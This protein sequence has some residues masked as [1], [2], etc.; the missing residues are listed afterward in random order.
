MPLKSPLPP[1]EASPFATHWRWLLLLI[2]F[3]LVIFVYFYP[4]THGIEDEA[5]YINQAFLWQHGSITA[6]GAGYGQLADFYTINGRSVSF[7]NP[8]RAL[9]LLPFMI[10]FGERSVFFTGAIIHVLTV[11]AAALLLVRLGKSPLWALLILLH[12]TMTLYSR[13]VMSDELSGL[14]LLLAVLAV[15]CKSKRGLLA[16]IALGAAVLTRYHTAV[17][18]PF[19]IVALFF[20]KGRREAFICLLTT[21]AFAVLIVAYNY[22]TFRNLVGGYS[23]MVSF[24][25]QY[26]A[27]SLKYYVPAL[28]LL[29]PLQLFAPF[30]DRSP[31]RGYVWACCFPVFGLLT[32]YFFHETGESLVQTL[33]LGQR[34]M[35]TILPIWI[36]SYI[37]TVDSWTGTAIH[38]Y[39]PHAI[40]V[41]AVTACCVILLGGTFFLFRE[42]QRHLVNLRDTAAEIE[43]VAPA[44][45]VLVANRN[46]TK[47]F[48][49][50]ATGITQYDWLVYQFL[51]QPLDNSA[52]LVRERKEWYLAIL[53]RRPG[54]ELTDTLREYI[55][56]YHMVKLPTRNPNLI[57]YRAPASAP[58]PETVVNEGK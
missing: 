9:T 31:L 22:W 38:K 33:I 8:G 12:P 37:F 18:V 28:L 35:L 50:P 4:P 34:L 30:I 46:L 7:R 39:V 5:G 43:Q 27:Y 52:R 25:P 54:D 55:T 49:T 10:A 26:L 40:R 47:L 48:G 3:Y 2:A 1:S 45:S 42:H 58:P 20:D 57:F 16:G 17:V 6:E 32:V 51:G 19:F 29:W 56:K 53:P 44:G 15:T 14:L 23:D 13:T 36:V 21:G 11:L 41:A 24:G